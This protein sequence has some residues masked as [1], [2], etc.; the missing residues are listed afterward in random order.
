MLL[1]WRLRLHLHAP[2][3]TGHFRQNT[4][5]RHFYRLILS[6][7]LHISHNVQLCGYNIW[8]RCVPSRL[9]EV[10]GELSSHF[11][12]RPLE[13]RRFDRVLESSFLLPR[14]NAY[15]PLRLL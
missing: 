6:D 5:L 2:D 7:S 14:D 15:G 9:E 12:N 11:A 4:K 10:L 8:C 1:A 3:N 13:Q